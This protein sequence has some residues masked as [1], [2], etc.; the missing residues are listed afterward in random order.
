MADCRTAPT[1]SSAIAHSPTSS[2]GAFS[3][4]K[5]VGD[6]VKIARACRAAR[7]NR[8][9]ELCVSAHKTD[10]IRSGSSKASSRPFSPAYPKAVAHGDNALTTSQ[11]H[12]VDLARS[13]YREHHRVN[14]VAKHI[15]QS[16]GVTHRLVLHSC[17]L[18]SSEAAAAIRIEDVNAAGREAKRDA[19]AGPGASSGSQTP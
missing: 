8:A 13:V 11:C 12:A 17:A 14:E 3:A 10:W 9:G 6:E 15:R 4:S 1:R 19:L 16:R 5:V 2:A 18:F 7:S